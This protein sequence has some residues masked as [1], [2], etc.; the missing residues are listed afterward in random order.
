MAFLT[1]AGGAVSCQKE[2]IAVNVLAEGSVES[3]EGR[4]N[5]FF[6]TLGAAGQNGSG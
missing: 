2:E 3:Q 6:C 4:W 5:C 1:G